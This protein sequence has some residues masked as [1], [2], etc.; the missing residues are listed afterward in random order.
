MQRDAVDPVG[1]SAANGEADQAVHARLL[2]SLSIDLSSYRR[3][4]VWEERTLQERESRI[5][6]HAE[7]V[8]LNLIHVRAGGVSVFPA[9]PVPRQG[10]V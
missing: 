5:V 1:V 4:H 10:A 9:P 3:L 8:P 6:R 7:K 2:S